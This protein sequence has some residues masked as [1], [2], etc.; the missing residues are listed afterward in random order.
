MNMISIRVVCWEREERVIV[1]VEE[2]GGS[3]Y[4]ALTA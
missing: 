3:D 1:G 2:G 4:S